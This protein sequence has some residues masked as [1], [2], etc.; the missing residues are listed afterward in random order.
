M[1]DVRRAVR[2]ALASLPERPQGPVPDVASVPA[3]STPPARPAQGSPP[4]PPAPAAQGTSPTPLAPIP[5]TA[6]LVLVAL[7]GGPDSLALAI[8]TAFEAP[9][10]GFRAGAVVVDHDLQAESAAVAEHAAGQA[11]DL[12]LDPVVVIRVRVDPSSPDGPEAAAR[13]ARYAAFDD[14]LRASAAAA[15][16]AAATPAETTPAETAP[17]ETVPAET[18]PAETAP[19][20]T[21]PAETATAPTAPAAAAL[22]APG[23]SRILLGH[24]LD[25]QAETV[26]LGLARG[27]GPSSLSGMDAVNGVFV[28][29]LLGIR[30]Q[31]VHRSVT[32][33]GL[34]AWNDPQNLDPAYKRVRVRET[35]LPMLESE[36]GPGIAEAL[37]RTADQLREDDEA[38]DALA[39][40]WA[41]EIVEHAE[42]GIAVD[43]HGL[44]SN[45]PALAQRIVRFVVASEF[46]VSLSRTQTLAALRLV[47][48]WH[49]QNG[50]DLPGIHVARTGAQLV[51]AR[52]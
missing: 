52:R 3:R 46:G 44:A 5:A 29:P 10:A 27:S 51:F 40:E 22:A 32:D 30:R 16:P 1:A 12:G 42:A 49:G 50:V 11:R 13:A 38:L 43:V 9:R 19:A 36:L 2:E 47:T 24:T 33:A 48:E 14:A 45:P 18:V 28:R 21:V 31:I 20:E 26:L 35:V 17:A 39:A 25:D 37:A 6:P 41:A 7:S 8:A 15:T 4:A 34:V 23:A